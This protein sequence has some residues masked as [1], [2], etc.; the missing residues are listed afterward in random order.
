MRWTKNQALVLTQ[1]ARR[2]A[3]SKQAV[4]GSYCNSGRVQCILPM[5]GRHVADAID[6][7]SATFI[8]SR[9]ARLSMKR[10]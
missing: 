3:T 6:N 8:S 10:S 9:I 2:G 4:T 7:P 1:V 5:I